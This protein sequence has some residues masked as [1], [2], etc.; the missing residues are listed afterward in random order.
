MT[1]E[2]CKKLKPGDLLRVGDTFFEG[3]DPDVKPWFG[4]IITF[5][6]FDGN[7]W[8]YFKE[9]PIAPFHREEII[10]KISVES[11]DDESV[12]YDIGD[13]SLIFGEVL[14]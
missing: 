5:E 4:E 13:I 12:P 11:I 14:T 7:K 2:E 10:E 3:E 6:R 8:I 9:H 1:L